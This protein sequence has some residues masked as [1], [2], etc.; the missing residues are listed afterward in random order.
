MASINDFNKLQKIVHGDKILKLV[1]EF[2]KLQ[3]MIKFSEEQRLGRS[4]TIPVMMALEHGFTYTNNALTTL[5]ATVAAV[6]VEATVTS[7]EWLLKSNVLYKDVSAM[8]TK[9][10]YAKGT[11]QLFSSMSM[12]GHKRLEL[13][14][15]YGQST[16]GLGEVLTNTSGAL[17]LTVASWAPAIWSGMVG[18]VLEAF[19]AGGTQHDGDLTISAVDPATRTITVTGTSTNVVAADMLFFKGSRAADVVGLDKIITNTGTLYGLSAAT[20]DLWKG[21]SY[22][23]NSAILTR[24]KVLS[25]AVLANQRGC[26]GKL[27][28]VCS[29][30]TFANLA[31]QES[32]LVRH[33][34]GASKENGASSLRYHGI[35]GEIE[36]VPS[37][38]CKDGEAFLFPVES[39]V[40]I[41]TSDMTFKPAGSD[42]DHIWFD[43]PT[44]NAFQARLYSDQTVFCEAP[45][46]CVKI[47]GIVNAG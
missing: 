47:T 33:G 43:E 30:S 6:F 36:V 29:P 39:I 28:L 20:Y 7:Y 46:Q 3:K 24:G 13:S 32:V 25:A 18:A 15:L 37:I 42:K 19:T 1:P 21:Q 11:T 23:A 27:H 14:L 8:A 26:I 38:F 9:A 40:R 16:S 41:G 12:S 17:V 34:E 4:F 44:Q 5:N 2:V 22:S 35:T 10:A 31:D 45:A